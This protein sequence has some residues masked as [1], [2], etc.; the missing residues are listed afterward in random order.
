[1]ELADRLPR[2]RSSTGEWPVWLGRVGL[3]GRGA[4]YLIVGWLSIRIAFGDRSAHADQKGAIAALLRQPFG[5]WMVVVLAVLFLAYAIHRF[6]RAVLDPEDEGW[7]KR[8]FVAGR[9]AL[10]LALATGAVSMA[11]GRSYDESNSDEQRDLA[12]R[13]LGWPGG[14]W[15]VVAVGLGLA[16]T[17]VWYALRVFTGAFHEDLKKHEMPASMERLVK[18][19]GVFGL[20]ARMIAFALVGWFLVH[21]AWKFDASEPVGL[22]ESLTR[23]AA[24]PW[25][26]VALVV[27]GVGLI[28]FGLFSLARARY[29]RLMGR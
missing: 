29:E 10:Y 28:S 1:M 7:A 16:A 26:R 17:G 19:V 15:I 3:V 23:V 20:L 18:A 22:D 4:I 14:R 9:G 8:L 2:R 5:R 24:A 12:L 21:L 27:V 11:L 13:V 25:G 6:S